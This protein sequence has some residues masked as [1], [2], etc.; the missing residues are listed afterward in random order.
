MDTCPALCLEGDVRAIME[1]RLRARRLDYLL[2]IHRSCKG[3][4]GQPIADFWDVW[5]EALKAA[6]LPAGR[7]FHDLR[8]S[9]VRTL[10]RAGVDETTAMKVSGHKTRSMSL[11]DRDRARD[12]RC[13]TRGG[14]LSLD[15]T[16]Q[17]Q[18]GR[19]TELAQCRFRRR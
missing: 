13:T 6:E 4:T 5:R 11:Q 12:G 10:I 15:A 7:L 16:A 2:I 3:K 18:R 9:A 14:R 8:R 1:R 17:P 19:S